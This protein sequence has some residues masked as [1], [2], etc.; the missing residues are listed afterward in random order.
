[1]KEL[2]TISGKDATGKTIMA[3]SFKVLPARQVL[4]L[5]DST[6]IFKRLW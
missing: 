1:M 2:A 4:L 3:D 6:S 5:P